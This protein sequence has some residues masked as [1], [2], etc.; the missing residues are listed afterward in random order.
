MW[1]I[2]AT[3]LSITCPKCSHTADI[4]H[5]G[6]KKQ[7]PILSKK[8]KQKKWS[9]NKIVHVQYV[10]I[11]FPLAKNQIW[12]YKTSQVKYNIKLCRM[13]SQKS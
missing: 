7:N 10:T 4:K 2:I 5:L 8:E 9:I 11:C 12:L 3:G 13:F 6:P 1:L